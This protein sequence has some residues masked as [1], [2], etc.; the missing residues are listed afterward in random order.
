M[1]NVWEYFSTG[2]IVF[3]NGAIREL[4]RVLKR[5]KANRVLLVTDPGIKQAALPIKSFLFCKTPVIRSSCMTKLYRN[6]R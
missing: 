4:D 2:Q 1:R 5:L 3:G 6:L